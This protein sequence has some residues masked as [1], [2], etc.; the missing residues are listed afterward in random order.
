[1]RVWAREASE[2]R[3]GSWICVRFHMPKPCFLQDCFVCSW[4]ELRSVPYDL[5]RTEDILAPA[6]LLCALRTPSSTL[7]AVIKTN[8]VCA[9]LMFYMHAFLLVSIQ[10]C[11]F[12]RW[13]AS[14]GTG[15]FLHSYTSAQSCPTACCSALAQRLKHIKM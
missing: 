7:F 11:G 1:V 2:E 8:C 10:R 13:A 4:I 14:K 3:K 9:C 15:T 12:L 6:T 5:F